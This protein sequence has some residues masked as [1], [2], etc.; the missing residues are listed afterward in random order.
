MPISRPS[1]SDCSRE[2]RTRALTTGLLLVWPATL[3]I[4]V[5]MVAD[6]RAHRF[7]VETA[8]IRSTAVI[9]G[10]AVRPDGS[11]CGLLRDRLVTGKRLYETGRVERLIVSGGVRPGYDEVSVMRSWLEARGVPAEVIVDDPAGHRT[12]AS[13]LNVLELGETR[14]VFVTTDFHLS[15]AVW[16]ARRLGLDASGVEAVKATDL[17]W[18]TRSWNALRE[19]GARVRAWLDVQAEDRRA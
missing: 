16:C 9:L 11:P 7:S 3:A 4:N 17:R 5:R 12:F 13:V 15:R 8:P 19:T 1:A 2:T 18:K 6:T 14:P 10:C